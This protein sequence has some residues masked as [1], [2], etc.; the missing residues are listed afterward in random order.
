VKNYPSS[1]SR[2]LFSSSHNFTLILF[3]ETI[4]GRWKAS[5]AIAKSFI[6]KYGRKSYT[7]AY[8]WQVRRRMKK[9]LAIRYLEIR[10]KAWDVSYFISLQGLFILS[11]L[12]GFAIFHSSNG[13]VRIESNS[14][15]VLKIKQ[16]THQV[17]GKSFYCFHF[18]LCRPNRIVEETVKMFLL[19]SQPSS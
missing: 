16:Q 6:A 17:D 5:I 15:V 1:L 2:A 19:K 12:R 9:V 4:Y 8:V 18:L 11:S 14:K 7:R 3:I 10:G 13:S